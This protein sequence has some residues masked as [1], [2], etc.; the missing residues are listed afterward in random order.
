MMENIDNEDY[1]LHYFVQLI[2]YEE[3]IK[4]QDR[5]KFEIIHINNSKLSLTKKGKRNNNFDSDRDIS[6][7]TYLPSPFSTQIVALKSN[8]CGDLSDRM[9]IRKIILGNFGVSCND[10]DLYNK[11][12]TALID[13]EE[14]FLE[15]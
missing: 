8:F 13:F 3:M 1:Y 12:L 11:Y 6:Y 7:N 4:S 5:T 2:N 10:E 9:E 14:A 15:N